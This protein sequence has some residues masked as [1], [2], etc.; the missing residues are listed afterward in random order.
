MERGRNSTTK[1]KAGEGKLDRFHMLC[2]LLEVFGGPTKK[3][4]VGSLVPF[5]HSRVVLLEQP[6]G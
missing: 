4:I 6:W 5:C 2:S 3:E 1:A